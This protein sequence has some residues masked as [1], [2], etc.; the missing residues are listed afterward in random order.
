FLNPGGS[1]KDR[2]G[3]NLIKKAE[4]SG[5]LKEG[6]TIIEPTAGNTGIGIA[7]AA[8][9]KSY[10]VIFVIPE[11]FSKEKQLLMKALG[12]KIVHTPKEKGM[13]GAIEKT[14]ELLKEIPNSYAP[15]QF[16]NPANPDTYYHSLGPEILQDLDGEVSVF[17]AGAG[18]GG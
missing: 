2:L 14:E 10:Q 1:I 7:L 18:T 6:G 5:Q 3:M 4:Q 13:R 11:H 16:K 12:A 9:N 8:V 17:L 15:Q